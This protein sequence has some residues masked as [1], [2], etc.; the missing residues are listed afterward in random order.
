M[1]EECYF[2]SEGRDKQKEESTVFTNEFSLG[3]DISSAGFTL[4]HCISVLARDKFLF[5]FSMGAVPNILNLD[6]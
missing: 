2:T 3:P 6:P 5:W 1:E 4:T